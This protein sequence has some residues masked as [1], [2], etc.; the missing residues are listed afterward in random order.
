MTMRQEIRKR[1]A[2]PPRLW[3][4]AV[5]VED[6]KPYLLEFGGG[7]TPLST[8]RE[9]RIAFFSHKSE[10]KKHVARDRQQLALARAARPAVAI[11]PNL[12]LY[13]PGDDAFYRFDR[14]TPQY[15]VFRFFRRN[16]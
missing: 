5:A 2:G 13:S 12:V 3:E 11:D 14:F 1:F 10:F 6:V 7:L 15:A 4:A 16:G 8:G 9:Q